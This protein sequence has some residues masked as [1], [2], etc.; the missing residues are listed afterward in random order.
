MAALR[1]L[2]SHRGVADLIAPPLE[3]DDPFSLSTVTSADLIGC[4]NPLA[5]LGEA[6]QNNLQADESSVGWNFRGIE[7]ELLTK[8]FMAKKRI[9][10]GDLPE[11]KLI[12]P[13]DKNALQKLLGLIPQ[14]KLDKRTKHHYYFAY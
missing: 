10:C 2:E 4:N 11:L 14:Q 7:A 13:S 8:I 6:V 3:R 9:I 12:D 1:N 5:V